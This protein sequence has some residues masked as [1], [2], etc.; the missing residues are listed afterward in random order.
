M[1][2]LEKVRHP[3]IIQFV[4]A[5]TQN[6][7]MMIVVEYHPKGDLGYY[8]QKKG[9]L[10]PSKSLRF[11]LD[12]A[13][14]INCLHE[15]KPD[16]VVHCDLKPKNVLLDNGGQLKVA[17][18]GLVRLS[19]ISAEKLKLA[20]PEAFAHQLSVYTAPELYK[21][22][23][24]DKSVDAFSFAVILYEMVEGVQPFHPK[25]A[26]EA[27]KLMCLEGKRPPAKKLKSYP[28]DLK[29]LIEECWNNNPAVR[30]SF[31]DIIARLDRIVA[32]GSKQGW[33]K[34]AFKLP[35]L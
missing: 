13:R 28:S 1:T 15:C 18:F 30:P 20:N 14:G 27:M 2:L 6:I 26:E 12:I 23:I 9:R 33:W 4:G 17:G 35:W 21:N 22:E 25:P 5:V 32:T 8:L 24:F 29:E 3:N 34:D 16:P 7:P 19:K 31:S 11:A 10:S